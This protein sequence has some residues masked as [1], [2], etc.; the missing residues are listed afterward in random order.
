VTPAPLAR[1]LAVAGPVE[2]VCIGL[3]LAAMPWAA[4]WAAR[5]VRTGLS[6]TWVTYLPALPIGVL[7]SWAYAHRDHAAAQSIELIAARARPAQAAQAAGRAL[8][9]LWLGAGCAGVALFI[10]AAGVLVAGQ[11]RAPA[12]RIT[13]VMT[14]GQVTAVLSLGVAVLTLADRSLGPWALGLVALALPAVHQT[15]WLDA[16]ARR[17]ACALCAAGGALLGISLALERAGSRYA[18]LV[19]ASPLDDAARVALADPTFDALALGLLPVAFAGAAVLAAPSDG[20]RF[21]VLGGSAVLALIGLPA[22]TL[23]PTVLAWAPPS[24]LVALR[25][26][27]LPLHPP[28]PP[29]RG[30]ISEGC[31]RVWSGAWSGGGCDLHA[32]PADAPLAELPPAPVRLVVALAATPDWPESIDPWRYTWVISDWGAPDIVL[33]LGVHRL[34]DG[35]PGQPRVAFA[36]DAQATVGDWVAECLA[37]RAVQPRVTCVRAASD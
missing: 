18:A 31:V 6:A 32:A 3:L 35:A 30:R 2:W 14:L 1:L 37:A 5:T 9:V 34:P 25:A 26:L 27:P 10:A 22:T 17:W 11:I 33:P 19:W 29:I 13:G 20:R 12:A 16:A 23:S 36:L 28:E 7:A 21:A 4:A 15:A 24:E 8:D